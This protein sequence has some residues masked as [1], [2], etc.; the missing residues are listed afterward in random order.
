MH[1]AYR[2]DTPAHIQAAFHKL[3]SSDVTGPTLKIPI[4][5]DMEIM[6]RQPIL[7]AIDWLKNYDKE[8][9]DLNR[10]DGMHCSTFSPTNNNMSN[11]ELNDPFKEKVTELQNVISDSSDVMFDESAT[12]FS[13]PNNVQGTTA[14]NAMRSLVNTGYELADRLGTDGLKQFEKTMSEF[15]TWASAKLQ[16]EMDADKNKKRKYV[17]LTQEEYTGKVDRVYNTKHMA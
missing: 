10:M 7:P 16:E 6:P 3:A 5:D 2:A 8:G 1:L 15:N 12:N 17:P 14:R 11:D 4:P 9:I 13:I